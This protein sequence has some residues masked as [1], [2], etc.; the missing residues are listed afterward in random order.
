M[1]PFYYMIALI[2]I[3]DVAGCIAGKYYSLTKS[4][5]LLALTA[6]MFGGAGIV[7]AKTLKYEGMAITNVLWIAL[8]IIA[9]TLIGYLYFKENISGIQMAGI[10]VITVGLVMVNV[11]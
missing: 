7:F 9:V 1:S 10:V 3:L 2:T 5:W 8:S 11:E 6:L 4:P